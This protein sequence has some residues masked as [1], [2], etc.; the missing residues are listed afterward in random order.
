VLHHPLSVFTQI[1]VHVIGHSSEELAEESELVTAHDRW[2]FRDGGHGSISSSSIPDT[3]YC[4]SSLSE[5]ITISR[6]WFRD[7]RARLADEDLLCCILNA[8]KSHQHFPQQNLNCIQNIICKLVNGKLAF[9]S[10]SLYWDA[11]RT[12]K[13]F[14][15]HIPFAK[16]K[17]SILMQRIFRT[18]DT[19]ALKAK[20]GLRLGWQSIFTKIHVHRCIKSVSA[21]TQSADR[22]KSGPSVLIILPRQNFQNVWHL[23]T[24]GQSGPKVGLTKYF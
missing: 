6:I 20:K 24:E 1:H 8:R 2:G 23:C 5:S 15:L 17:N 11:T 21:L 19:Y 4:V 9:P 16:C 22:D 14:D 10:Y 18:Y 13:V 3:L 7:R 12:Q